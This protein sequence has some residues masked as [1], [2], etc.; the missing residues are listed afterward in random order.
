[1]Y[2]NSDRELTIS[3]EAYKARNKETI[4]VF[5]SIGEH[6]NLIRI[7]PDTIFCNTYIERAACSR[8]W[9]FSLS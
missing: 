9:L 6:P 3:Y 4:H 1:M 5:D 8:Q 7:L 2:H